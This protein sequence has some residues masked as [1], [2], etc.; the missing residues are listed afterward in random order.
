MEP[1][2]VGL[3][4]KPVGKPDALIGHVRFDERGWETGRR[5]GVSARAH[6]RLYTSARAGQEAGQ[7]LSIE[8][9]A[10]DSANQHE[11]PPAARLPAPAT[12]R[13][14]SGCVPGWAHGRTC[15]FRPMSVHCPAGAI[16]RM[17]ACGW[18]CRCRHIGVGQQLASRGRA[19]LPAACPS[20]TASVIYRAVCT[21]SRLAYGSSSSSPYPRG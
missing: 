5:F 2:F 6:P 15:W 9:M 14:S 3:A 20:V 8:P 7:N 13:P 21:P 1:S 4:V 17:K 19:M 11:E 18:L 10:C 12:R 16:Q